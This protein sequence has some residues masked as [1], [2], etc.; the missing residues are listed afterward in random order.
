M[1]SEKN[2]FGGTLQAFKDVNKVKE[3]KGSIYEKYHAEVQ[4]QQSTVESKRNDSTNEGKGSTSISMNMRLFG[5]H[6]P[7]PP[8]LQIQ[9]TVMTKKEIMLRTRKALAGVATKK[10]QLK[11]TR[12]VMLKLMK[13]KQIMKLLSRYLNEVVKLHSQLAEAQLKNSQL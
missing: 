8:F 4:E 6:P 1:K 7:F 13:M 11:R 2:I 5:G 9:Q 3:R 10:N 12:T